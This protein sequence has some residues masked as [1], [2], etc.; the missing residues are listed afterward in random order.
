M[1]NCSVGFVLIFNSGITSH[2]FKNQIKLKNI[3]R[4]KLIMIIKKNDWEN[5]VCMLLYNVHLK[6]A[7]SKIGEIFNLFN[8]KKYFCKK[9]I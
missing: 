7:I 9:K 1:K 8:T 6:Y 4:L 5:C 2:V 3:K